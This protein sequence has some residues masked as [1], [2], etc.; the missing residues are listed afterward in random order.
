[1]EKQSNFIEID[2]IAG[3]IEFIT[4]NPEETEQKGR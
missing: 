2:N 1:M 4:R 3:K